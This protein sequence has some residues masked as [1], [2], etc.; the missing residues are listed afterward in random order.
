VKLINEEFGDKDH[1]FWV[2]GVQKLKQHPIEKADN[3]FFARQS[4]VSQIFAYVRLFLCCIVP[5]KL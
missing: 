3:I 5:K 2:V 4:V 1:Q